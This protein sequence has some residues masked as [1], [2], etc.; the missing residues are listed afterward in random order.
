MQTFRS[1]DAIHQFKVDR[2][3][4]FLPAFGIADLAPT[5]EIGKHESAADQA[6]AMDA[7]LGARVQSRRGPVLRFLS[8]WKSPSAALFSLSIK[9][10]SDLFKA[11]TSGSGEPGESSSSAD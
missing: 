3:V 4:Y 8:G 6:E 1:I 5:A 10:R 2:G 7:L 11:W 9:Q